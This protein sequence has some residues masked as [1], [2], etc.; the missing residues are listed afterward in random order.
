VLPGS[1]CDEDLHP[2]FPPEVRDRLF[3]GEGEVFSVEFLF[4]GDPSSL[5]ESIEED[6][7]DIFEPFL[8]P[9][10]IAGE[11]L[12]ASESCFRERVAVF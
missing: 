4:R 2:G 6:A 3:S 9:I 12:P 11:D 8:I 10:G 7:S 1:P 5:V